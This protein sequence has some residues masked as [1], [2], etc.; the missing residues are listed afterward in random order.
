[1]F[2]QLADLGEQLTRQALE[3]IEKKLK[4]KQ[5]VAGEWFVDYRRLRIV[6][7]KL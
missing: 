6:A 7:D 3:L 1:M 4:N 5:Y 2:Q